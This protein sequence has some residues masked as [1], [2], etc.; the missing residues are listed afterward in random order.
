MKSVYCAVRTGSLNTA[1]CALPLKG[2]MLLYCIQTRIFRVLFRSPRNMCVCVCVCVC[3]GGPNLYATVSV[4][5]VSWSS[6]FKVF[7]SN[8][9]E[10]VP[11]NA[12]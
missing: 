1:V 7:K 10:P 4:V 9:T 8:S 3:V 5:T 12:K 11:K 2:Y 6:V